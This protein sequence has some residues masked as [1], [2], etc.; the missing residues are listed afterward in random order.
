[1]CRI[2]GRTCHEISI[3]KVSRDPQ[4]RLFCS[5]C[6]FRRLQNT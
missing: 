3:E 2:L 1:M 4:R 5:A 6:Y